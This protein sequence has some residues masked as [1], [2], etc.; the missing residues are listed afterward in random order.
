MAPLNRLFGDMRPA[1]EGGIEQR[2]GCSVDSHVPE[3]PITIVADAL[4][5]QESDR[6][7]VEVI[8][9]IQAIA[10]VTGTHAGKYPA[11]GMRD[12]YELSGV[13]SGDAVA[14]VVCAHKWRHAVDA[15]GAQVVRLVGGLGA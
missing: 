3:L 8:V 15:T 10:D 13:T 7:P 9:C 5:A 2:R 1:A 4:G 14:A 6:P 11:P 12:A